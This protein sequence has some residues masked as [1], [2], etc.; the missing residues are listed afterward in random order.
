MIKPSDGKI[1]TRELIAILLLIIGIKATDI[2][3]TILIAEGKNAAWLIPLVSALFGMLPFLLMFFLFRRYEGRGLI[4]C[5]YL[6]TGNIVGRFIT[7]LLLVI[8]FSSLVLY[9]RSTI[10]VATTIFY[11]TTPIEA[12]YIFLIIGSLFVAKRGLEAIGRTAWLVVP[13][14]KLTMLFLFLMLLTSMDIENL[15]P[16]FGPGGKELVVSGFTNQGMYI[17]LFLLL[18][19]FAY[20]RS[21]RE[22]RIAYIIASV[23][24][25]VEL[26]FSLAAYVM[27]LDFPSVEYITYPFQQ[28]TRMVKITGVFSN[29]E[30][31]FVGFWVISSVVRFAM[32]LYITTYIF[33][34]LIQINEFEPLLISFAGLTVMLGLLPENPI[35]TTA[36]IENY[37]FIGSSFIFF[38]LPI[39]LFVL[40]WRKERMSA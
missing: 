37:L 14:V 28:V 38:L 22:G 5:V 26:S 2:T 33:G 9:S 16:L 12:I 17:E 15:F 35:K 7:F 36:Y 1:G 32:L 4:D 27:I 23:F 24:V 3:P 19:L 20:V 21:G 11:P 30:G 25:V 34:Q 10:D 6:L 40:S 31:F 13:W 39:L 18:V 29:F 8:S